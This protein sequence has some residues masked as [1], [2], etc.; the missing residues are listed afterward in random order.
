MVKRILYALPAL[1]LLVSVVYFHGLFGKIAVA[2]VGVLC[3]HEMMNVAGMSG[4]R[5]IKPIGYAFAVLLYPVY[6]FAGG[7]MGIMALFTVA[8]LGIFIVLVL[9][10]RDF[11]DGLI[12][13]F[14]M[15]Y[16]GLLYAFL[17]AIMCISDTALS[18]FMMIVAFSAS[19]VT[20]TFAYF[21]GICFG[22]HK[23]IPAISPKKS[24][25]GAVGGTVLGTLAVYLLGDLV[26]TAFG[27]G[28][29]PYWYLLLGFV[30]SVLTQFG[31]LA[32][33]IVKRKYG[34][35]DYGKIMGEHGGMMDRLDS[36][37]FICPIVFLFS[38]LI[39]N[40]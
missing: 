9:S 5:P 29:S 35:K 34:T 15:V 28:I 17:L 26:Q 31:D 22:R 7:F 21:V 13:V 20:D 2:A 4:A 19:A 23:L 3:M 40:V 1:A 6:Q 38:Y 30:L 16:P 10:G 27:V 36:V 33:S 11:G 18:R 24:V 8:L 39:S 12:T 37:L 14:S 32:A 25:E